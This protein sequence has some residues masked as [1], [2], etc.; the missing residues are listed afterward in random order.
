MSETVDL[1]TLVKQPFELLQEIERRSLLVHSEDSGA[2]P[3]EWVGVGFRIG[4]E[5]FV[6]SR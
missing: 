3:S 4:E 6:A 2:L 1:V 5:Q